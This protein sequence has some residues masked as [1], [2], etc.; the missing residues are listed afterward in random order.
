LI[1]YADT[2]FLFSMYATDAHSSAAAATL[3]RLT[4]PVLITEFG[5]FE[6]TN[7]LNGRIFQKEF[8]ASQERAILA[9]FSKD[10]E[11]GIVRI[12]PLTAATF[13]RARQIA[14]AHTP[15]L[16]TRALDVLHVASAL[17]LQA[18]IFC[19]FDQKQAALASAVG[20]RV[21]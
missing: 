14:R 2:S 12:V 6:F 17:T 20:L 3:R 21:P 4:P 8:V 19:T 9:S 16:G 18:A 5:E 7:A 11:T 15:L 13:A 10:I 1:I